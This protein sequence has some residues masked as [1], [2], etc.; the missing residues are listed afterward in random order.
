M[1]IYWEWYKW[2]ITTLYKW[3]EVVN[4]IDVVIR[5]GNKES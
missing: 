3:T 4:D 2:W 5:R 1:D